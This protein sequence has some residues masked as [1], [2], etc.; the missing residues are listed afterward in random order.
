MSAPRRGRALAFA[1]LGLLSFIWGSAWVVL[2]VATRDAAPLAIAALRAAIGAAALLGFLAAARRPLRPPPF[3]PT[4]V[5][6]L[7]QTVGFGLP[8][9]IAVALGATG[10]TIVLGYT[11]PFWLT[12]LAWVFLG[13]RIGRA[14]WTALALA[15]VGLALVFGPLDARS[16]LPSLVGVSSGVLWAASV[17]WALRTL[18]GRGHDLLL[19]TAWQM[20]WG[21]IVLCALA[22]AFPSPVHVTGSFV[23]SMAFLSLVANALGWALWMFV[24]SRLSPAAAGLGTLATPVVG[25]ALAA[26][27]LGEIPTRLELAGMAFIVAALALN[28]ATAA[29]RRA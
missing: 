8:Q 7:L 23:A 29:R 10:R 24:L 28:A 20:A 17:V 11:M 9:I 22:L 27:R 13:E 26:V 14:R 6:G 18:L 3:G 19:V 2:K 4:L 21:A 16:M 12:L 1:T 15:A 5:L 25:V